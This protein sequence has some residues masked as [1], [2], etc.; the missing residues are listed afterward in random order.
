MKKIHKLQ[1]LISKLIKNRKVVAVTLATL[2]LVGISIVVYSLNRKSS[3]SSEPSGVSYGTISEAL[4]SSIKPDLAKQYDAYYSA[5]N[6]YQ[7]GD[8]DRAGEAVEDLLKNGIEAE[9]EPGVYAL[10]YNIYI[11]QNQLEKAKSAILEYQKTKSYST[12]SEETKKSWTDTLDSLN[13]GVVPSDPGASK[14]ND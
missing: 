3:Q 4:K 8:I 11:K 7:R 1:A 14:S 10:A 5:L 2:L 13:N 12:L 6:L 9:L